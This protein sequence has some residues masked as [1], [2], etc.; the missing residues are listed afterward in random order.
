MYGTLGFDPQLKLK[1]DYQS[2]LYYY[3]Y[4]NACSAHGD[5]P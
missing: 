5:V 1:C 2:I 3:G 4:Y